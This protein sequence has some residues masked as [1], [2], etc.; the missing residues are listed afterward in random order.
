MADNDAFSIRLGF[1][2]AALANSGKTLALVGIHGREELSRLFQLELLLYTATVPLTDA[3]LDAIVAESCV[4]ALGTRGSDIVHGALSDIEHVSGSRDGANLYKATMVPHVAALA[5]A[6]RSAIYQNTTVPDMVRTILKA[7]GLSEGTNFEVRLNNQEKSPVHEYV[8]QYQETD[9]DFI[10]RWLEH[11]G[12]FYWFTHAEGVKLIVADDNADA[13]PIASPST[14]SFRER[15]NM[16]AGAEASVWALHARRQRVAKSVTLVDY[17]YRRP[18]DLLL[19]RAVVQKGS[20]GNV[21]FYGDH[22]KDV[23]VGRALAKI[24]AEEIAADHYTVTGTTDCERMRVG[25]TFDL[26]NHYHAD[27]DGKY[28]VTAIDYTVGID[29][30]TDVE[31]LASAPQGGYR[32]TIRAIPF[33]I[34]F[35]PKRQTPWPSIHGVINAHIESDSSGDYAQIDENGRYKLKMPFDIAATSGT[36]STRW[37]RMAQ[38]SAGAG[39]GSHHPLRKGT[40][41]I[42]THIDGDPDRPVI[43]SSVPNAATPGP[44]VDANASQSVVRTPS[45]IRVI[46]EDRQR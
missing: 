44:V 21:F 9:W 27:Y 11:E 13:T 22:F 4:I 6:E 36:A 12:F 3:E 35:R 24:R 8:V 23:N 7:Y 31:T 42:L 18:R 28:L 10:Q 38:P 2:S 14:L 37:V 19:A 39:Y 17:N 45:G 40:E 25:H 43:L 41:V 29:P 20:F 15:N 26:E 5:L 1:F 33:E 16:S 46:M 34:P 32:A 30:R